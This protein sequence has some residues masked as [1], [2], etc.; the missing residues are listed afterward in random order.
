MD[1][2]RLSRCH[3]KCLSCQESLQAP[4]RTRVRFLPIRSHTDVLC[5]CQDVY[6]ISF[7]GNGE[8]RVAILEL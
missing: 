2:I 5:P 1:C 7:E 3:F 6:E 8:S 4:L